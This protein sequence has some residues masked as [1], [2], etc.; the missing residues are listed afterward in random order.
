[1][2]FIM[3]ALNKDEFFDMIVKCG[4]LPKKTFSIGE[5]NQ[6]RY[7]LECRLL[8]VPEEEET[9]EEEGGE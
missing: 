6:K 1:M 2:G 8:S 5:E 7:Y 3:P 4:V 9:E